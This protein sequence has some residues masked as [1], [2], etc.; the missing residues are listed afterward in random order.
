MYINQ[1]ENSKTN[2]DNNSFNTTNS[3]AKFKL[4]IQNQNFEKHAEIKKKTKITDIAA[5]Q[6]QQSGQA[7]Q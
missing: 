5:L 1:K 7:E 3:L 2:S 6:L 4:T